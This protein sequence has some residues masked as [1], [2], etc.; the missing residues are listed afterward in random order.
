MAIVLVNFKNQEDFSL[1]ELWSYCSAFTRHNKKMIYLVL[2]TKTLGC[3]EYH[4]CRIL[5]NNLNSK[6]RVWLL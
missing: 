3:T 5:D 6:G 1:L 2:N 4:D